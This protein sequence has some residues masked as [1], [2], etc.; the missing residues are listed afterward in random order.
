MLTA[1]KSPT[2]IILEELIK[3]LD[4]Y[5]AYDQ[6]CLRMV[7]PRNEVEVRLQDVDASQTGRILKTKLH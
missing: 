2:V 5:W 7:S 3:V 4:V 1:L 6:P